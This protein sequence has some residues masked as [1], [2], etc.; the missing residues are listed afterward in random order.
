MQPWMNSSRQSSGVSGKRRQVASSTTS[1]IRTGKYGFQGCVNT[2][3]SSRATA[4]AATA[5]SRPWERSATTVARHTIS[6]R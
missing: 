6:T 5:A 4:T 3:A 2:L 1:Q